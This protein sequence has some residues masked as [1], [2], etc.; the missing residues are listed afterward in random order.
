MTA[1][2][3]TSFLW[4]LALAVLCLGLYAP[5][6]GD[7][8]L[9]DD[10][11]LI[12]SFWDKPA[13]YFPELLWTNESGDVWKSW[14][15]DPA[16]GRGY[17]RPLKIWLLALEFAVFGTDPVGFHA[18]SIA[19]F[20]SLVLLFFFLLRRALPERAE[21]AGAGACA[22]ALHPVLAEVV[23]FITATE[24][25]AATAFGLASFVCFLRFREDGRSSIPFHVFYALG[26]LTKESAI[27]FLALPLGWDLVQGRVWPPSAATAR[28]LARC[29]GPS[30]GILAVYFGLRWIAFG[31]FV[32]GDGAP[33]HYL[34]PAAFVAFHVHFWQSLGDPTLLGAEAV[35]GAAV[36]AAGLLVVLSAATV[37]SLSRVT[38]AR[39]RELV[40]YGPLWYLGA[41]A[42]LH[43]A[44]FAV[45]HNLLPVIGLVAFVTLA[46][47]TLLAARVLRA[48]RL[49]ALGLVALAALLFL[50]P[51]LATS[52]D[53]RVA[54]AAVAALR[55]TIE[56]RT[57]GL[58]PGCA[59][60]LSGVPQWVLPPFF[61]GWGLRSALQR[62]FTPSD[63]A[64]N[65]TVVDARNLELTRERITLPARYDA[66][67]EVDA[68]P[69]LVPELRERH[70][71]RLWREGITARG[72]TRIP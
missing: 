26:L 66:V 42:I 56:E 15:I 19:F 8:F 68:S 63:L 18:V 25:L 3:G 36:F 54:A 55:A 51:T 30:A 52:R 60:S 23:P 29:Y 46:A 49:C 13:V 57:A 4:C 28:T 12:H 41:T 43:G 45:R 61:F 71:R 14:G 20:A 22:L 58:V 44:Y 21:L 69:W 1:R 67:I 2:R 62:P 5:N 33:T 65:C 32:G 72:D 38:P 16:L 6:L 34:S 50:P 27:V 70:L 11:D 35:P 64:A 7:Y 9:G 47:D 31:N 53:W 59:V 37:T 17:L 24:E 48:P 40:F 39:R 10:F